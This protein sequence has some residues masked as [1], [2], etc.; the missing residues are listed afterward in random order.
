[1]TDAGQFVVTNLNRARPAPNRGELL[2]LIERRYEE[3]RTKQKSHVRLIRVGNGR[4]VGSAAQSAVLEALRLHGALT[5]RQI[6]ERVTTPFE[7]PRSLDQVLR[8]FEKRGVVRR[9]NA[10]G[11]GRPGIWQLEE[12]GDC[13]ASASTEKV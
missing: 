1:L 2:S 3:Y 7:N 6:T 4:I 8:S 10:P 9:L 12:D 13:G 5:Q 11:K